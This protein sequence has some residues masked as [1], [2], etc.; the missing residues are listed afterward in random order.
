MEHL[1]LYAIL[2]IENPMVAW[3]V[4]IGRILTTTPK[5][6]H[7]ETYPIPALWCYN[8]VID[9]HKDNFYGDLRSEFQ[10]EHIRATQFGDKPSRLAGAFFFESYN[11][12]VAACHF[13]GWD[14]CIDYISEIEFESYKTGKFDSNWIT[15]KVRCSQPSERPPFIIKYLSGESQSANPIWE[16]IADGHGK[17]LNIDLR[18]M[19]YEKIITEHPNSSLLLAMAVMC[20]HQNP[21]KYRE[22]LRI[23]PYVREWEGVLYGEF[24]LNMV[25]YEKYPTEITKIFKHFSD[26]KLSK[27][28]IPGLG[29]A[30]KIIAPDSETGAPSTLDLS[31]YKFQMS[32]ESMLGHMNGAVLDMG[33]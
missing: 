10:I 14:S 32:L 22:L 3:E 31:A 29:K 12:A 23:V 6:S 9:S 33:Q 11:D 27:F 7:G 20:Y 4:A 5:D 25:E 28:T 19:A 16:I 15:N 2:N 13:W 18:R 30:F 24:I 17:I 21:K 8:T 26:K 1:K